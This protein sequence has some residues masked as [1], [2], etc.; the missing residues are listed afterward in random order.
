MR[1]RETTLK[2][3]FCLS[4]K[5]LSMQIFGTI[6]TDTSGPSY[7]TALDRNGLWPARLCAQLSLY[8]QI[9]MGLGPIWIHMTFLGLLFSDFFFRTSHFH[10][11]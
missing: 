5:N 11:N 7:W 10:H 4:F 1:I 6:V 9:W 2:V 8:G 3:H